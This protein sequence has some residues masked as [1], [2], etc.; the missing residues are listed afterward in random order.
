MSSSLK[1]L[2]CVAV[3]TVVGCS[4]IKSIALFTH[5]IGR[6]KNHHIYRPPADE[7]CKSCAAR[8][9]PR[10]FHREHHWMAPVRLAAEQSS[11]WHRPAIYRPS[12]LAPTNHA[13]PPDKGTPEK[14]QTQPQNKR[15]PQRKRITPSEEGKGKGQGRVKSKMCRDAMVSHHKTRPQL[16]RGSTSAPVT[17]M[18]RYT[19]TVNHKR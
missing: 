3:C 17:S 2:Q 5:R 13:V 19:S 6:L 9:R 12:R 11:P 4:R 10:L 16:G 1:D 15:I 18:D 8:G 7:P 14:T